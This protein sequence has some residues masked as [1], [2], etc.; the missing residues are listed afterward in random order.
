MVGAEGY[1]LEALHECRVE[2]IES[3]DQRIK[4]IRQQVVQLRNEESKLIAR[5]MTVGSS[6]SAIAAE[7]ATASMVAVPQGSESPEM[8]TL[9]PVWA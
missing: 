7:L 5:R 2:E 9:F 4:L 8:P 6:M 1:E 3:I